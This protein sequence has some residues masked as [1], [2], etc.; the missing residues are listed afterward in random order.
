MCMNEHSLCM[1]LH[2][3]SAGMDYIQS[4]TQ[5]TFVPGE[6]VHTITIP[7]VD[8][9][10]SEDQE[11]FFISLLSPTSSLRVELPGRDALIYIVDND[12]GMMI[13]SVKTVDIHCSANSHRAIRT[14]SDA[15]EH[16]R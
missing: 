15:S 9:R 11:L 13:M 2:A 6:F 3:H 10:L 5:L 4:E 1:D 12:I 16:H 8:D 14:K 7:L